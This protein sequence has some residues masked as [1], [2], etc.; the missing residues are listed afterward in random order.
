[1]TEPA[2]GGG[3]SPRSTSNQSLASGLSSSNSGP[4]CLPATVNSMREPKFACT[5]AA[6][7][8]GPSPVAD[9]PGRGTVAALEFVA[10][11]PGSAA[12][13]SL[14]H[15]TTG[16]RVERRLDMFGSDVAAVDVV[17]IA[18]PGLC[19]DWQQPLPGEPWIVPVDPADDAGVA[20]ADRV[21][22]RQHDRKI[23]RSGLV[24]PGGAGH[25]AVAVERV[26][27]RGA[28]PAD[29]FAAAR[30]NR[31]DAGTHRQSPPINVVTPTST[32]PTSVI[33]LSGPG[34]PG[35]VIPRPRARGLPSLLWVM[36]TRQSC[37]HS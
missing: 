29:P 3:L 30:Q 24:D 32:P 2:P 14:G 12:D 6:N 27:A 16:R 17:E 33:A 5:N 37:Q 25:L 4:T 23:E 15:R 20:G 36:V 11:H 35:K 22:I 18:V 13:R 28:R 26:P 31:G 34:S 1:M 8:E 7:R 19:A 9:L 10:V 21:R